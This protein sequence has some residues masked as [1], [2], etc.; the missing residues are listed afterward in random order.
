MNCVNGS[1]VIPVSLIVLIEEQMATNNN[2]WVRRVKFGNE[3]VA[4]V[5]FACEAWMTYRRYGREGSITSYLWTVR[6]HRP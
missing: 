6:F 3:A 4:A 1:D 5:E 2:W